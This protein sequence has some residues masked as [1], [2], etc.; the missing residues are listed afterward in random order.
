MA[1]KGLTGK[2]DTKE[3]IVV[4]FNDGFEKL[5]SESEFT[6]ILQKRRQDSFWGTVHSFQNFIPVN[7]DKQEGVL[8]K[9]VQ[10]ENID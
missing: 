7:R 8:V 1:K 5:L 3:V 4:Q 10:G 9:Y 2:I 6:T